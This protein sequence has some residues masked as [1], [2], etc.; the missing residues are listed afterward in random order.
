MAYVGGGVYL[1]HTNERRNFFPFWL[2]ET[3]KEEEKCL[4]KVFPRISPSRTSS[5]AFT[6]ESLII[7]SKSLN[8]HNWVMK[9]NFVIGERDVI[10][11]GFSYIF[12]ACFSYIFSVKRCK[13]LRTVRGCFHLTA[14]FTVIPTTSFT[15]ICLFK[16]FPPTKRTIFHSQKPVRWN[17]NYNWSDVEYAR[18]KKRLVIM[19]KRSHL[20]P[21]SIFCRWACA[22][23]N[24]KGEKDPTTDKS[25]LVREMCFRRALWQKR[26]QQQTDWFCLISIPHGDAR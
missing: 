15:K 10:S 5:V 7:L 2:P 24:A 18:A 8:N 12:F 1:W 22:R 20:H 19:K 9:A 16:S 13:T 3:W 17:S 23:L 11:S 21:S 4:R 26:E 6:N 14:H 25:S